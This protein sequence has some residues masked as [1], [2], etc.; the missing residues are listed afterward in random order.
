[1]VLSQKG[2]KKRKHSMHHHRKHAK[3]PK[4]SKKRSVSGGRKRKRSVK[5][6]GAVNDSKSAFLSKMMR[7]PSV[8]ILSILLIFNNK[9]TPKL[10]ESLQA[11][12]LESNYIKGGAAPIVPAAPVPNAHHNPVANIFFNA[13][14]RILGATGRF[15]IKLAINIT[16]QAGKLMET[17]LFLAMFAT[18]D[19][20]QLRGKDSSR[21][22]QIL[23]YYTRTQ[24]ARGMVK[25]VKKKMQSEDLNKK[26]YYRLIIPILAILGFWFCYIIYSNEDV[27]WFINSLYG[28]L[29]SLFAYILGSVPTER[30][31]NP[32]VFVV[33]L[34]TI[35]S[36]QSY[37]SVPA[38]RNTRNRNEQYKDAMINSFLMFAMISSILSMIF[39]INR[40]GLKNT[41]L[42]LQDGPSL[43]F[44]YTSDPSVLQTI[45]N[46]IKAFGNLSTTITT[47]S[48]GYDKAMM[49]I[50]YLL[51][52]G[53]AANNGVRL[54]KTFREESTQVE[55]RVFQGYMGA[56]Y[57][58]LYP[59]ST[60]V[61]FMKLVY[62]KVNPTQEIIARAVQKQTVNKPTQKSRQFFGALVDFFANP[63][64]LQRIIDNT[65]GEFRNY[66][67]MYTGEPEILRNTFMAKQIMG[68]AN[69]LK[70][71]THHYLNAKTKTVGDSYEEMYAQGLYTNEDYQEALN[72][73][74]AKGINPDSLLNNPKPL[75]PQPLVSYSNSNSNSG[76]NSNASQNLGE[77]S[78]ENA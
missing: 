26:I 66:R 36:V 73:L 15:F 34:L 70:G 63:R 33:G 46:L 17:F 2:G 43:K 16:K 71:K 28:L 30:Y 53:H 47:S 38:L 20:F 32:D 13:V 61:N 67:T 12:L 45:G 10:L 76:S 1:M 39:N 14:I 42:P 69:Y 27:K 68:P 54:I 48:L 37:T 44:E 35:M 29:Q 9:M 57:L 56:L 65:M 24:D 74:Q 8:A 77:S 49:L 22:E 50:K 55:K 78:N 64:Q 21:V 60:T 18:M 58:V 31:I 72:M 59:A 11:Y 75:P 62:K 51:N 25:Y 3:V 41:V 5:R 6:G 40:I 19:S 23:K 4:K 52:K 7:D